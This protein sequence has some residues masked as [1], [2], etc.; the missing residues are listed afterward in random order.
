[1][2][3]EQD[4]ASLKHMDPFHVLSKDRDCWKHYKQERFDVKDENLL[5]EVVSM[6]YLYYDS[7]QREL[8]LKSFSS[9]ACIL[10]DTISIQCSIG[11]C[12]R[13]LPENKWIHEKY[14]YFSK[15]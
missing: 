14:F 1:M 12:L 3:C 8:P 13:V 7:A 2:V 4:S 6:Y 10:N 11:S 15:L 5:P 9:L